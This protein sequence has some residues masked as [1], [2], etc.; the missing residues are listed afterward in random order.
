[1][2]RQDGFGTTYVLGCQK[3]EE[4]RNLVVLLVFD[5]LFFPDRVGFL[6]AIAQTRVG[7]Y[8]ASRE[9]SFSSQL[10]KKTKTRVFVMELPFQLKGKIIFILISRLFRWLPEKNI[11]NVPW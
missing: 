1:M 4:E 3:F 7:W 2:F 8:E 10:F 5:C 11:K 6:N 9:V